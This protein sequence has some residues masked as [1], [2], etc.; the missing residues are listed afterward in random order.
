MVVYK[1]VPDCDS[2]DN[3]T[4]IPGGWITA[5]ERVEVARILL[6]VWIATRIATVPGTEGG[7][8]M[9]RTVIAWC[10][11]ALGLTGVVGG[12]GMAYITSIT[13]EGDD[14]LGRAVDPLQ[15][16]QPS[17]ARRAEN[18]RAMKYGIAAVS[19]EVGVLVFLVGVGA[20]LK[21]DVRPRVPA[22]RRAA[23]GQPAGKRTCAW[24]GG[25][26]PAVAAKCYHC[27]QAFPGESPGRHPSDA[28]PTP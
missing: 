1:S 10:L 7:R 17:T 12:I 16:Y 11:I 14:Q 3:A 6:T 27:G 25:A 26:S 18:A 4:N 24:C 22:R 2:W 9:G 28:E 15:P 13:R 19:A 21:R 5:R 8:D 23:V 20:R